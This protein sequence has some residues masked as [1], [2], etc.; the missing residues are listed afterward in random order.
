MYKASLGTKSCQIQQCKKLTENSLTSTEQAV[1]DRFWTSPWIYKAS[2]GTNPDFSILITPVIGPDSQQKQHSVLE[3]W[4][5]MG[6]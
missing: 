4:F 6:L 3:A 2:P 1:S 5:C